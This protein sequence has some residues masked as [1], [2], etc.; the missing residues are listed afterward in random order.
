MSAIVNC[1]P[2]LRVRLVHHFPHLSHCGHTCPVVYAL[3]VSHCQLHANTSG[4]YW[5]TILRISSLTVATLAPS[6]SHCMS[7][8]V[9][10]MLILRVR[11]GSPFSASPLL[12]WLLLP[13]RLR[14]ACRSLSTACQYFGCVLVRHFPY[15]LSLHFPCNYEIVPMYLCASHFHHISLI[16][17]STEP[18]THFKKKF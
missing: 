11:T 18:C 15:L 13:R 8:I 7:A 6:F 2:T 10:S 5:V 12:L 14:I 17:V 9:D 1:M 4:A 3:H 16:T